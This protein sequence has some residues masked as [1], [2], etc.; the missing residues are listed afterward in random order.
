MTRVRLLVTLAVLAAILVGVDRIAAYA[1]ERAVAD[2]LQ[3]AYS[4]DRAPSVHIGG[5]PF[6]TQAV[7]GV[8]HDV[9]VT[10]PNVTGNGVPVERVDVH[11]HN[12]RVPLS[13][14]L[15]RSVTE[16]RADNGS[17]TVLV[18]YDALTARLASRGVRVSAGQQGRVQV[19]GTASVLGQQ[20]Q[21]SAQGSLSVVDHALLLTWGP[22]AVDVA[23]RSVSIGATFSERVPIP[24]LPF[25][26]RLASVTATPSGVQI[27]A[28]AENIVVHP[29]A[30]AFGLVAVSP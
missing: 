30:T 19:T 20:V 27:S 10:A 21:A 3:T 2:R 1:A 14:V 7:S 18:G 24:S 6:L 26:V 9:D 12:V 15:K 4:L 22:E 28:T 8:Y 5:F 29:A 13:Q 11:L 16:V 25:D 23:G 17:G